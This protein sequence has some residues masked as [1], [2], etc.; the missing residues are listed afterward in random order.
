MQAGKL[1]LPSTVTVSS[2]CHED[3][4]K[5]FNISLHHV[6]ALTVRTSCVNVKFLGGLSPPSFSI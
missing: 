1:N 4:E 3:G 5:G 6:L 2:V